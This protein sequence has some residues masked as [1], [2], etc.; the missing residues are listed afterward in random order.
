MLRQEVGD[1]CMYI[2]C[3]AYYMVRE[4]CV[5]VELYDE[6]Q[7]YFCLGAAKFNCFIHC[8]LV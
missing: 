8:G 2:I 6:K 5:K 3:V 1:I 4:D 7:I